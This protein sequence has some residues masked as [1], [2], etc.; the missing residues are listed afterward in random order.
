MN[1]VSVSLL[2]GCLVLA[3][4]ASV[5]IYRPAST[6]SEY[7]YRD[8]A[9]TDSRFLVSFAGGYGVARETVEKLALLRAAQVALAHGSRR[10]RVVS[11]ET[12]SVTGYSVPATSITFGFGYPFW[13]SGVTYSRRFPHTRYETVLKIEIGPGLPAGGPHIYDALELKRH[14][15]AAAQGREG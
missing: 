10:L 14:L 4:C 11:S 2:L 15:A 9:L 7:G 3:G 5:P 8:K 6:P 12:E 13:F 1:A